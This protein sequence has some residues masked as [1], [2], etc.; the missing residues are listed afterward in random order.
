MKSAS[1]TA[2]SITMVTAAVT[3][4]ETT[5]VSAIYDRRMAEA[6]TITVAATPT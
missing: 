1:T 3:A 6:I 4:T 5:A 2:E